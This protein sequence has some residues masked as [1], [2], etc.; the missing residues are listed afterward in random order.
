MAEMWQLSVLNTGIKGLFLFM[1]R[2]NIKNGVACRS[3]MRQAFAM[4]PEIAGVSF[5][6]CLRS[7]YVCFTKRKGGFY[8]WIWN[9]WK[10]K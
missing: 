4:K 6:M 2:Y 5:K 9:G 8:R 7:S 10:S 1:D 3:W